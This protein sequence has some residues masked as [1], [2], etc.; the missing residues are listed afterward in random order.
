MCWLSHFRLKIAAFWPK[1]CTLIIISGN[2]MHAFVGPDWS[3]LHN[4]KSYFWTNTFTKPWWSWNL[5]SIC[6]CYNKWFSSK[7]CPKQNVLYHITLFIGIWGIIVNCWS[8]GVA[9][10]HNNKVNTTDIVD[11]WPSRQE[12]YFLHERWQVPVQSL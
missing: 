7:L 10:Q 8:A 1:S 9:M 11:L 3:S 2:W 5:G 6:I 4:S 12:V